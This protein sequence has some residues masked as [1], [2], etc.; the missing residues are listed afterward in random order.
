[1]RTL[2]PRSISSVLKI[3]LD[4][5]YVVLSIFLVFVGLSALI[6]TVSINNPAPFAHWRIGEVPFV[7][8][9]PR[10]AAM[11]L[12][13]ALHTLGLWAIVGLLRKVFIT[14]TAGDPFVLGNARRL[15]LIGLILAGIELA[16]YGM[17]ALWLWSHALGRYPRPGLDVTGLFGIGVMFV[18]AE[19]FEA[20]AKMRK[21]LELTI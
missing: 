6:S 18:L 3:L 16:H 7:A 12:L 14:L 4:I 11:I 21:D 2:G 8:Q 13:L 9:S 19:V 5:A 15:R 20:G 1:M 10:G 17:W